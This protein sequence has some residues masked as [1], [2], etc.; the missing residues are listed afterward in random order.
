MA[1]PVVQKRANETEVLVPGMLE[2]GQLVPVRIDP[3]KSRRLNLGCGAFKKAGFTNL[4]ACPTVK[5]DII[6]DLNNFPYPLRSE[7]FDLIEA[8][9]LLEHLSDPF[10][11][12]GELHRL[13]VHD[14]ELVIRVPHFSRGFTHAE[15]KRGFDVTFPFYFN[16]T[17]PGGY[18]GIEFELKGLKLVWFAQPYLKKRVLSKIEYALGSAFGKVVDF[19]ANLSPFI[20]SRFWCFMAGGFEEVEFRFVCKK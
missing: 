3:K 9:H 13:L 7:S 5:P 10:A 15:H 17:F 2:R 16:P 4:D 20:C 8:D 11:V 12:M 14:G 19:F 1:T 6:H 18:T